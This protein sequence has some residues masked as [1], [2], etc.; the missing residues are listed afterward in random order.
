MP[1]MSRMAGQFANTLPSAML[2]EA[3][4]RAWAALSRD[5]Q[6]CRY[7]GLFAHPD[8]NMFTAD[9]PDD[10]LL[11]ARHRVAQRSRG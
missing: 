2:T 1:S 10:I 7:R 6:V 4:I 3:A 11:A 8:C 9:T 5:Q